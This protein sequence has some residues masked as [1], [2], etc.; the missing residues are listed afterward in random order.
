MKK[1]FIFIFTIILI[2]QININTAY[3]AENLKTPLKKIIVQGQFMLM[4]KEEFKEWLLSNKFNRK[5]KL[6]EEHHTWQPSYAQFNGSNYFPLL[7]GMKHYHVYE[8]GFSDIAQN[9]TTFPDGKV[10]VCRPFDIAPEGSIGAKANSVGISI[11]NI[12]NFDIGYDVMTI[13]Q[14][15]TIIYITALLC[16]KF[17]LTP[18]INS[19]TYHHWWDMG[20][21][22]NVLD[23][24][25]GHSIKTCPGTGFFEGNDT[26]SAI[27]NFYPLVKLKIK[28]IL[29]S[30]RS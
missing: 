7:E 14:K 20:T 5:I 29:T 27:N 30:I 6:I 13:K 8:R 22:E 9:I 17:G 4:T 23:N 21:G 18:S 12:G 11:E 25:R 26:V 3:A 10:A 1:T 28:E 16:I 24:S 2:I 19:I 15:E